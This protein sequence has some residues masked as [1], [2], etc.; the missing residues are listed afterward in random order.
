M[1]VHKYFLFIKIRLIRSTEIFALLDDIQHLG[2]AVIKSLS[3]T[4]A[5]V[6]RQVL[7]TAYNL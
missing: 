2:F 7:Y 1:Q 4:T 6:L 5:S 3:A